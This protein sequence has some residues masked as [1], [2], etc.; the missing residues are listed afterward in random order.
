MQQIFRTLNKAYQ[1]N[2]FEEILNHQYGNYFLKLRSL[3]RA[4]ILRKLAQTANINIDNVQGRQLF[5]HLFCQN[6]PQA[7]IDAFIRQIYQQERAERIG[8]EEKLIHTTL[9]V[10][11]I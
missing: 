3:S 10:T 9:S 1:D 8:N 5:K 7:T 6:I 4:E 2:E 11:S